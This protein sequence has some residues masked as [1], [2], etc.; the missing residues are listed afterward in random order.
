MQ[1]YKCFICD[2]YNEK[3]VIFKCDAFLDKIPSEIFTGEFDHTKKHPDQ[4]NN[5]LFE[6]IESK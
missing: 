5:I 6:P 4:D 1:G 3:S 2:H